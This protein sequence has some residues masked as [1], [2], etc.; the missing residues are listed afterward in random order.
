M[1]DTT[2]QKLSAI[3]TGVKHTPEAVEKIRAASLGRKYPNRK[4][5]SPEARRRAA[6]SAS[7]TRTKNAKNVVCV[8]TGEVFQSARLAARACGVSEATVSM[9][10]KGKISGGKP[11][12]GYTFRYEVK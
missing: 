4:P 9:H 5:Q 10:C 12:K 6:E 3:F 7:A 2:K 11:K 1:T 8:E